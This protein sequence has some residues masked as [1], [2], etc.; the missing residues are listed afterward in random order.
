[1]IGITGYLW[2][3]Y[4]DY[5]E[6]RN[7]IAD[8]YNTQGANHSYDG[9][10]GYVLLIGDYIIGH[11]GTGLP[12]SYEYVGGEMEPDG[13]G[14]TNAAVDDYQS[15]SASDYYYSCVT[16]DLFTDDYDLMG[17]LFIGRIPAG[18]AN[19]LG[20]Y[21]YKVLQYEPLD[22][23][24]AEGWRK[25]IWLCNGD[26]PIHTPNSGS[27]FFNIIHNY[28]QALLS[29][30]YSEL[31][32]YNITYSVRENPGS[33][34]NIPAV[35]NYVDGLYSTANASCLDPTGGIP[36][37]YNTL[38]NEGQ[39]MVTYDA[40]G[41][42]SEWMAYTSDSLHI[43]GNYLNY[44]RDIHG[45]S[46]SFQQIEPKLA[47][48]HYPFITS[49]SCCT[50]G[51]DRNRPAGDSMPEGMG[52]QYDTI[53]E[54]LTC[55]NKYGAIGYLGASRSS[56]INAWRIF[57]PAIYSS[58]FEKNCYQ[59]GEIILSAKNIMTQ[60]EPEA[61]EKYKIQYTLFGDP[62]LNI[63]YDE[64]ILQK[65]DFAIF[66]EKEDE[67]KYK[68]IN[69]YLNQPIDIEVF[70]RNIGNTSHNY[71]KIVKLIIDDNFS[72]PYSSVVDIE[73]IT[74]SV[75]FSIGDLSEG[76]HDITVMI[77]NNSD[78]IN[79]ENNQNSVKIFV[80]R[81]KENFPKFV[82]ESILSKYYIDEN[83]NYISKYFLDSNGNKIGECYGDKEIKDFR[84]FQNKEYVL[85][86]DNLNI[87]LSSLGNTQVLSPFS[88]TNYEIKDVIFLQNELSESTNFQIITLVF[89]SQSNMGRLAQLNQNNE[90]EFLS[91]EFSCSSNIKIQGVSDINNDGNY[92]IVVID[93]SQHWFIFDK[94]NILEKN[95]FISDKATWC[96]LDNDGDQDY[97]MI[98]GKKQLQLYNNEGDFNF[99]PVNFGENDYLLVNP[100]YAICDFDYD[101]LYTILAGGDTKLQTIQIIGDLSSCNPIFYS[102]QINPTNL[103]SDNEYTIISYMNNFYLITNTNIF[104]NEVG[105]KI[106]IYRIDNIGNNEIS[107]ELFKTIS[108]LNSIKNVKLI[109]NVNG[110]LLINFL[111][112]N[113][114]LHAIEYSEI[115]LDE[116]LFSQS[117]VSDHNMNCIEKKLTQRMLDVSANY[118]S[119]TYVIDKDI[120]IP[121]NQTLAIHPNTKLLFEKNAK[122]I[123]NGNLNLQGTTD[124]PIV[125][126]AKEPGKKWQ[127]IVG[128]NTN[129]I[130][131]NN[132][133]IR[134]AE[135]GLSEF[136]T[137]SVINS[138]FDNCTYALYGDDIDGLVFTDNIITN[139]ESWGVSARNLGNGHQRTGFQIND[140][141]ISG[142]S[143]AH[144]VGVC[145][146]GYNTV[147]NSIKNNI[148]SGFD[149]GIS[150]SYSSVGLTSNQVS[151][152]TT[153]GIGVFDCSP[154]LTKNIISENGVGLRVNGTS[155]P[156]LVSRNRN[157]G[158]EIVNNQCQIT[159]D[160]ASGVILDYGYNNIYSTQDNTLI[161]HADFSQPSRLYYIRSN[162]W[163][164]DFDPSN[165]EMYFIPDHF[166]FS[167]YCSYP[168]VISRDDNE[169][170]I[171]DEL[172]LEFVSALEDEK[173]EDFLSAYE[174]YTQLA[175]NYPDSTE[176]EAALR[177]LDYLNLSGTRKGADNI[178]FYNTLHKMGKVSD[179]NYHDLLAKEYGSSENY[180]Y[181]LN[182][183]I[184]KYDNAMSKQDSIA[185]EINI[186][187]A[188]WLL[189]SVG[190]RTL[191]TRFSNL[192]IKTEAK[193]LVKR[194]E[195]F[196]KLDSFTDSSVAYNNNIKNVMLNQNYPNPFNPKTTIEYTLPE[197]SDV[198]L[199][200][201]N[202]KGELVK[203]LVK[204]TQER[205]KYSVIWGGKDNKGRS[206]ASGVYFSVLKTNNK[207]KIQKM[208]LIK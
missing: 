97:I 178:E 128:D 19:E 124:Q 26:G 71:S 48:T 159:Y 108:T 168:N 112:S 25:N 161:Y 149:T 201:Y 184:L 140:N 177:R 109:K 102:E 139:C 45:N 35:D 85:Q 175:F 88:D 185:S 8:I 51:F 32:D 153:T 64:A 207:R 196:A 151:N 132:V 73:N 92:N 203:T 114:L 134:D 144:S 120:E 28:F 15:L 27:N 162:F 191:V 57:Q 17:D 22:S 33:Y 199:S 101:G 20:N 181:S 189:N 208:L 107:F 86:Y 193:Y 53:A 195:L 154:Y 60:Y 170:V 115:G 1:L 137:Y 113:G 150:V 56:D 104:N 38:F 42:Y 63:Y 90:S 70:C 66:L 192:N 2:Q 3:E 174:R 96:D 94:E 49:L 52:F 126:C 10:L 127:G 169:A 54:W 87:Y 179:Y 44:D 6:I 9:K 136:K 75:S 122:L 110:E 68:Y 34:T 91:Q 142:V 4:A 197:T 29:D 158:N 117:F 148:V 47:N 202:I 145:L 55:H 111:T 82:S 39:W 125:F 157:E 121:S 36:A 43:P 198:E 143:S 205:N 18:D 84:L 7:Y 173:N 187:D 141:Q 81:Y 167:P 61:A 188:L 30:F 16:K 78:E 14:P 165:P 190:E 69:Q 103:G 59:T 206:V 95:T 21:V 46:Y 163:G 131:L 135:K 98:K 31:N 200:I 76:W 138:K 160:A 5:K 147:R 105:S 123:V 183:Y 186:L 130:T 23:A 152:N 176:A 77:D 12:P 116:I 146:Y 182:E 79:Y 156:I 89:D 166:V 72:E 58:L 204:E 67:I 50:G 40:H 62:A 74:Q 100:N 93:N 172:V 164:A 129:S 155:S 24:D 80:G 41:Y 106:R 118:L 13:S 194:Q 119:G 83:S 65:P 180:S 11:P 99:S 133:V 37:A 171:D